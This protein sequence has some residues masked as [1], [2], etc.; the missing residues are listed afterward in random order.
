MGNGGW[1]G[2]G[3]GQ[4]RAKWSYLPNAD[5]DFIFA[6]IGEELGLIGAGILLLLFALLAYTGLRIARRNVDPFVK[7]VASAATVWLVGQ[8]A[9]NIGYV[10]G[11]LPVTGIPLPMISAG[12]TS[13]LI[14]MVVFGLLANFARREP[15][16][17]AALQAGGGGRIARSWVCTT[18]T[19]PTANPLSA[20]GDAGRR[21]GPL[22]HRRPPSRLRLRPDRGPPRRSTRWTPPSGSSAARA[23]QPPS[24]SGQ[25]PRSGQPALGQ[26][27]ARS[28]AAPRSAARARSSQPVRRPAPPTDPASAV[29]GDPRRTSTGDPRRAAPGDPRRATVQGPA[30]LPATTIGQHADRPRGDPGAATRSGAA[31]PGSGGFR[32]RTTRVDAAG[33]TARDQCAARRRR[34]RRPYRTG[35]RGG[36]CAGRHRPDHPD[37]RAGHRARTGDH[38]G[39]GPWLRPAADPGGAVAAQAVRRTCSPCRRPDARGDQGDQGDHD[40]PRRSTSS[41]GFG[42]YVAL[43]AYLAARGRVPIVIH[44]ANAT[45]GLANKIGARFAVSVAA[46][47]EGSGLKNARVVG[48]PVR[49]S[50]SELDRAGLRAQAREF[51]GLRSRRPDAAGLRRLAGC[52]ADQRRGVGGR[53]GP[54]PGRHRGAARVR[55]AERPST[56]PDCRPGH[57]PTSRCRTWI[58][59]TWPTRRPTWCWPGP[60][61]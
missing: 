14:T 37:H 27:R 19:E 12:G 3:L 44:E 16:A 28:A 40:R 23:A 58:G 2:V 34:H 7:I 5:S 24:R 48:N 33:G 11:L 59:W 38:P 20:V 6:I 29:S 54:R 10:V 39:A 15:Q 36:R 35:A 49:R 41:S 56:V 21:P 53:T 45:A 22:P 17:A 32:G 26:R 43:P 1:F 60:G 18:A 51:F 46:A 30:P 57:R 9:I 4:S 61:R 47:V 8:A 42:G 50:L 13:L 31:E 55:Q 25:P 52:A